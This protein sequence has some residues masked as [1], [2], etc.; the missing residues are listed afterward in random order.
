MNKFKI[1]VI[2]SL[3]VILIFLV[4]V[5]AKMSLNP[6]MQEMAPT[7]NP[8][9]APIEPTE[10]ILTAEQIAEQKI[11][12]FMQKMSIEQK[13]GQLFFCAFRQ[14]SGGGDVVSADEGIIDTIKERGIGGVIL[15]S[16]NITEANQVAGYIAELQAAS[17]IAL[18]VGI[19]EEGGRVFRTGA[20]DVPRLPPALS[21]GDTGDAQNAR[22]AA[23]TIAGYLVPLGF[24]MDFA[25]VADVFTNPLNTVIGDRA[26]SSNPNVAAQMVAAYV[27]GLFEGGILPTLKHFPGHGDTI[28]DSHY[29]AAVTNKSLE[30]LYLCEFVPFREGIAAGA[31]FVMVGAVQAPNVT[32]DELPAIFSGY[33]IGE[34]L[35][36]E[37]E[38]SGIVITDALDMGAVANYYSPEEAA[39]MAVLAGVDMLLMPADF[40]LAYFG[41]LGA[42]NSGVISTERIDES[43]RRIL[44]QKYRAGIWGLD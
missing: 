8:T 33:L 44:T 21:I 24:N 27:A 19:D 25:P 28:E 17:D 14:D 15:F 29:S 23:A 7:E 34:I 35:R 18:F 40:E 31:P 1:F 9:Q 22:D 30:E 16:E 11:E 3:S 4:F 36:G 37:L 42:V 43:V 38:F 39:V 32:G 6:I 13:I 12:A 10:E 41:L 2:S 5:Y 20:L 26:F